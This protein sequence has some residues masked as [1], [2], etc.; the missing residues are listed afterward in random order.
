MK[1]KDE[2]VWIEWSN[3]NKDAYGAGIFAYAKKW[4]ETME[5]QL[6]KG[7]TVAQCANKTSHEADVFGMSGYTYG[8]SVGILSKCW[9]HGEELRVWHN[10]DSQIGTE[11]EEANKKGSVLNPAILCVSKEKK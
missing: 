9:T 6:E 5:E 8:V 11:G 3:K 4:A 2:K 10:I 1:Y 7:I